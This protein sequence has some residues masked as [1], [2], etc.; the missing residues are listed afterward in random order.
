[1]I[2]KIKDETINDGKAS[3]T[4]Y[5]RTSFNDRN[6]KS[7]L[8][9]YEKSMSTQQVLFLFQKY[10]LKSSH[11]FFFLLNYSWNM[12]SKTLRDLFLN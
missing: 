9:K 5:I 7:P 6:Y 11:E 10:T 2:E 3:N 1:M 12:K 8:S 4:S